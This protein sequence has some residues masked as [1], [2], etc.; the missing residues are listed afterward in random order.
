MYRQREKTFFFGLYEG[1]RQGNPATLETT[2]PTAAFRN[3]DLSALLGGQIGTDALGRPILSGQI[4]NP[5]S[6][7]QIGVDAS[8]NPIYI[9]DPI[10]GNNLAGLIDPVAKAIEGYWPNPTNSGLDN[11]FASAAAAPTTSNEF[12][13]RIDHNLTDLARLYGRF[14]IKHES[15]L[16]SAPFYGANNPGG[17]GQNNPDNR[18]N[19]ALGYSQVITPTFT[20]TFNLG[21]MRWVEGND[22]QSYPFKV[23]SL[24]LPAAID[25]NSPQFPVITVLGQA[26]LGPQAGAGQ[27]TFPNNIGSLG[28]DFSK[29]R[30]LHTFSFGYM[31]ILSQSFGGRTPQPHSTST[32]LS[33]PVLIRTI[34]LH[35]LALVL[36]ASCSV[37][38]T[39]APLV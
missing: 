32:T 2:V 26:G 11:N 20:S 38:P 16:V 3:G 12:S 6:T 22:V 35:R 5:F 17:P 21:F 29:V 14:S 1:L 15:K 25:A 23:S 33:H 8:G 19:I 27:G 31:G 37:R 9:R 4:Y 39:A 24:G 7:R 10:P 34:P 28:A 18:W 30:G 13:I 36:P